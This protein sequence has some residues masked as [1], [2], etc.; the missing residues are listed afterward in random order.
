MN[1]DP[2][3]NMYANRAD[4]YLPG[5]R[6]PELFLAVVRKAEGMVKTLRHRTECHLEKPF[7]T[8]VVHQRGLSRDSQ[9]APLIRC[10]G[11]IIFLK[12]PESISRP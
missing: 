12:R 11:F 10:Q 2:I 7:D 3:K 1:H 6:N 4:L 5:E 8:F 9:S